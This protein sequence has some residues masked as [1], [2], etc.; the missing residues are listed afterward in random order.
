[1]IHRVLVVFGDTAGLEGTLHKVPDP[2]SRRFP[3]VTNKGSGEY[4]LQSLSEIARE[5]TGARW[6]GP[7]F[8]GLNNVS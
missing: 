3:S 4:F 6:S 2:R 7:H 5:I 8:F 1:M